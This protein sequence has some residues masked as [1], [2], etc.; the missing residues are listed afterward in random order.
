MVRVKAIGV[1]V[2][3]CCLVPSAPASELQIDLKPY[4]DFAVEWTSYKYSGQPLPKIKV[5]QHE[6]VQIFAYGDY[7]YAQFEAKGIK[8]ATVNAIYLPEK[9]TIYVSDQVDLSQPENA[10][11]L[12]HEMVHY[13]QDITGYTQSLQ[14]HLSCTESE[15]YDV[16]ML[17]QKFNGVRVEEIP[18]IYSQGLLAA[19]QCRGSKSSVF[20]RGSRF[21]DPELRP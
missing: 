20:S 8:P 19:T 6:L 14:G 2:F 18:R 17:W 13:L 5:A 9:K 10:P 3:L 16:Q 12:I 11:T 15:A 4:L 7:E 21:Q 1:W